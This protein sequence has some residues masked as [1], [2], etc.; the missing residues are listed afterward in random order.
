MNWLDYARR[1]VVPAKKYTAITAERNLTAV[2]AVPGVMDWF[3][4][5]DLE[6]D[7]ILEDLAGACRDLDITPAEV[8][9]ELAPEDIEDWRKGATSS[10]TQETR[11]EPD[12][13]R[14]QARRGSGRHHR[15]H[16][17]A[18]DGAGCGHAEKVR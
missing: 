2:M 17:T 5:K 12:H 18:A 8:Q 13:R 14:Q 7:P 16:R 10:D 6:K 11:P 15:P 9:A 1:E 4:Y 3:E